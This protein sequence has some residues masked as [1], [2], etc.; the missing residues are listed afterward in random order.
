M[1][2]VQTPTSMRRRAD[3]R[4]SHFRPKK[5]SSQ[6][7]TFV[8]SYQATRDKTPATHTALAINVGTSGICGL[9]EDHD[10]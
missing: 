7:D 2:V 10:A 1:C 8:K 3:K 9:H 6:L 4:A 5:S